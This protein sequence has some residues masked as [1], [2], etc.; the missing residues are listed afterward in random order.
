MS[1]DIE[2]NFALPHWGQDGRKTSA[3]IKNLRT[4]HSVAVTTSIV[5]PDH[6]TELLE[7]EVS[8]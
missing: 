4:S 2:H 1:K 5:T 3:L 6:G 7:S 8:E